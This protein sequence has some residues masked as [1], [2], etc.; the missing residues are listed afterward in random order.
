VLVANET[1][2]AVDAD[3][4]EAAVRLAFSGSA[5]QSVNVSV[6]I[7]D[8]ETIHQLNRQFLDHDYPTDVL[9]FA[10]EDDPPRLEGEI[11]VSV[12][13]AGRCAVEA[14]WSPASEVLLYVVHGALH[15]AG[16]SDKDPQDA[17][18]MRAA[19]ARL[20]AQLDVSLS[21]TDNRWRL[22]A[23]NEEPSS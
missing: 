4:L 11:V 17:L 18:E 8:D 2:E 20:L 6:A 22:D 1:D 3:R 7:V 14:G 13:T 15:L 19:E 21:P 9:S 5:Y 23:A 10:L 16:F 12:D